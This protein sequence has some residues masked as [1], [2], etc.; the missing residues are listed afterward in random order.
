MIVTPVGLSVRI[1]ISDPWDFYTENGPFAT[2][3]IIDFT[4]VTAWKFRIELDAPLKFKSLVANQVYAGFRHRNETIDRFL[5]GEEVSCNFSN[6][7]D[8]KWEQQV[9]AAQMGFI[10]G[11][12]IEM[13]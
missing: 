11:L 6:I 5:S 13:R 4:A 2:G 8:E 10:G 3:K 12:Q 9:A 7:P 1:S